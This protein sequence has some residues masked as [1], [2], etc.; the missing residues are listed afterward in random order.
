V[1]FSHKTELVF[2]GRAEGLPTL[3]TAGKS[4]AKIICDYFQKNREFLK[5]WDPKRDVSFYTLDGWRY[6]L[7][8]LEELQKLKQGVYLLLLNPD[9]SYLMGVISFSNITGFPF[10]GCN[11]G[12]S[13]DQDEQGK[14]L[15][16]EYLAKSCAYMFKQHNIHR[17][18]A[19]YLPHNRRSARVLEKNGFVYEGL[20]KDYLL[21]DGQWQDHRLMSLTNQ[22]WTEN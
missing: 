5:P 4:D 11:L 13:L 6:K 9:E 22:D 2:D 17:I 7:T 1:F 10:H 19:A 21:I 8:R 16:C 12:Y 18:Q 14:G 3:R 15:M 20:A